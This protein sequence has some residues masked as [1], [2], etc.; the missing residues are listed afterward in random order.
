MTFVSSYLSLHHSSFVYSFLSHECY[1]FGHTSCHLDH[2]DSYLG[3][4]SYS[5][6]VVSH[7]HQ[8]CG[9][10]AILVAVEAS[11]V[12]VEA[13]ALAIS[14]LPNPHYMDNGIHCPTYG[15]CRVSIWALE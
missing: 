1:T 14:E 10:D 9:Y 6:F 11:V 7:R 5:V 4:Y 13:L 12:V 8:G 2:N 15:T 3:P